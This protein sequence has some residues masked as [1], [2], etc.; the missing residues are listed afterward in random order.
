[1]LEPITQG[2]CL[3]YFDIEWSCLISIS[4]ELRENLRNRRSTT[5]Q[6]KMKH[7]MIEKKKKKKSGRVI[8]ETGKAK[9]RERHKKNKMKCFAPRIQKVSYTHKGCFL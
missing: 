5:I 8:R 4:K 3:C 9:G 1:M 2:L 7:L 6:L